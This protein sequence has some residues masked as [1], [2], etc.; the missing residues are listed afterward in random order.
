VVIVA[1]LLGRMRCACHVKPHFLL[2]FIVT[3]FH[4]AGSRFADQTKEYQ[5]SVHLLFIYFCNRK[6]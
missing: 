3:P 6:R 2:F 1:V 4:I 5:I